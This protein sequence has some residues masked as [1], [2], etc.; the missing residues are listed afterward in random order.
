[1]NSHFSADPLD[2]LAAFIERHRRVCVLTG[3]GI[4][5]DSGIPDYRDANGDWKRQ[6][7]IRYQEFIGSEPNRRRYW[8]RS[9]FGWPR[10]A[11]A[12][13]NLAHQALV[14]LEMAGFVEHIITQNVDGLHQQAGSRQVIDLHGRLDAVIC[15]ECPYQDGREAFQSVLTESNPTFTARVATLGPDGDAD[16]DDAAYAD[17]RV[18]GCPACGGLLKPGVVFFGEAVPKSRVEQAYQWLAAAEALLVI[19]SSLTVLSG[20]RFCMAATAN[21]QPIAALNLGRTRADPELTLKVNRPCGPTLSSL[22]ERL[23]LRAY[24]P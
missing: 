8:A 3:A 4:S 21:G 24:S 22:V 18:P 17:F 1:M 13:P 14:R 2:Q 5:T 10:F 15:L 7:P 20:Y 19:G 9:W 11:S 16:L 6:Q 12:Q 23:A